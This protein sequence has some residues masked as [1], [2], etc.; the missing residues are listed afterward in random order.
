M[1]KLIYCIGDQAELPLK[2]NNPILSFLPFKWL[3]FYFF[4]DCKL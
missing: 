2:R 3:L 1:D 4:C